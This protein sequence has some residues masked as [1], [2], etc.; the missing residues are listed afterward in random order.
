MDWPFKQNRRWK[1][2]KRAR[3]EEVAASIP[4]ER[5]RTKDKPTRLF[6]DNEFVTGHYMSH[7]PRICTPVYNALLFHCNT[8]TQVA[9]PGMETLLDYTGEKNPNTISTAVQILE[10]FGIIMVL[11]KVGRFGRS[12]LYV[13]QDV[14]YWRAVDKSEGRIKIRD[15]QTGTYQ[16]KHW[17]DINSQG[18]AAE[19]DKLT[20]LNKNYP[21][22]LTNRMKSLADQ[23]NINK[24]AEKPRDIQR[25]LAILQ[26]STHSVIRSAYEHDVTVIRQPEEGNAI[27]VANAT[28][29]QREDINIDR[30]LTANTGEIQ[31]ADDI[32]IDISETVKTDEIRLVNDINIDTIEGSEK[33]G[34]K[35]DGSVFAPDMRDDDMSAGTAG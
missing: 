30:K 35:D 28:H 1:Q 15:W 19:I 14:K 16:K 26:G 27:P 8:E 24:K 32:N 11:R 9:F 2:D 23:M 34:K 22:E 21:N 25:E 12:N 18:S 10:Y 6:M 33:G 3:A 5:F 20:N 31:S 4:A 7:L 29:M 13:F 17:L